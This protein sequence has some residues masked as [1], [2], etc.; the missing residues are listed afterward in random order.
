MYIPGRVGVTRMHGVGERRLQGL[1]ATQPWGTG[2]RKRQQ[3]RGPSSLSGGAEA[4]YLAA[5]V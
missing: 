5:M 2:E 1:R 4:R 3:K